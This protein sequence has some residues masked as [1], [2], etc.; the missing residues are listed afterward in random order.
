MKDYVRDNPET[1]EKFS[2]AISKA[3]NFARENSQASID[4]HAQ[5]SGVDRDIIATLFDD[6]AFNLS[7][8]Q[9]LL[10]DLEDQARWIIS[11]GYTDKKV[12]NFLDYIYPDAL[13]KVK[14]EAV[15]V[16][17]EK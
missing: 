10:L 14:P 16:I 5:V 9:N 4:I 12:P 13:R 15:T 6:M 17:M 2:R 1:I 7:L 11:Y 8:D 3:E